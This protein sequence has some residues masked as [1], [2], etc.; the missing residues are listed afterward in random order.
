MDLLSAR[1]VPIETVNGRE[2]GY[3]VMRGFSLDR[4][5][6]AEG[7]MAAVAAV[8]QGLSDSLGPAMSDSARAKVRALLGG[9]GERKRSWIRVELAPGQGDRVLLSILR[10]A[11]EE[12][13]IVAFDYV[14][15][16]GRA[17]AR[18]VEPSAVV[19]LWQS[20]Y[21]YAFCR[22]RGDWRLFKLTRVRKAKGLMERFEPRPEP[23][24]TA[25]KDQWETTTPTPLV[26]HADSSGVARAE[27][28]FGPDACQPDGTGGVEVRV[29]LPVNEWLFGFL[30]SL[31]L[32]VR[33]VEPAEIAREIASR[34]RRIA[35]CY[36]KP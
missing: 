35:E 23:S 33:V 16:E 27:E 13:R 32:G 11:I 14:D 28:W 30:L 7:E 2:G 19:Y 4:S 22:L 12:R 1:G 34:A 29:S 9:M 8:L 24:E 36:A 20:W 3:R 17:T 21:L 6:L 10:A 31:G 25:W 15:A 18:T 5:V 26:L